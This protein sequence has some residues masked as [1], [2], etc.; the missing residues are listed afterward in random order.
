MKKQ[1][2]K[3]PFIQST[4]FGTLGDKYVIVMVGLPAR[5]NLILPRN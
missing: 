2:H 1:P 4:T 5:V 3:Q